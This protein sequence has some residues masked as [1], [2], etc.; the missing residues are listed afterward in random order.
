M[1][2]Q[3]PPPFWLKEQRQHDKLI[4]SI[5]VLKT[6]TS[7]LLNKYKSLHEEFASWLYSNA[8]NESMNKMGYLKQY[9]ADFSKTY[10][11]M[12]SHCKGMA[13]FLEDAPV[14]RLKN[15]DTIPDN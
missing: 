13:K 7:E 10:Y 5:D 12:L 15:T 6:Q 3:N 11:A 8:V 4:E 2:Q 9:E 14:N 1:K